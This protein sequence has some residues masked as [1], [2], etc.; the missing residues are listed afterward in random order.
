MRR[1]RLAL[2]T[3]SVLL[4]TG[5]VLASD[6]WSLSKLIPFQKSSSSGR[7]RATVSDSNSSWLQ[8]PNWGQKSAS[9]SRSRE[10]STLDKLS[11]G[12]KKTWDKTVD[13]LNPWDGNSKKSAAKKSTKKQSW[14]SSW[15][16]QKK[17]KPKEVQT[18]KD[19]LGQPRPEF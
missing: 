10:P 4:V 3:V 17:S 1:C 9:K 5:S 2:A 19:F 16:P 15:M 8:L 7:A 12:T 13:L 14:F 18:V 11:H 6:G